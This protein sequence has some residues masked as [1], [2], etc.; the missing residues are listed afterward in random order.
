MKLNIYLYF[1]KTQNCIVNTSFTNNPWA[2][3]NVFM[4]PDVNLEYRDLENRIIG[5]PIIMHPTPHIPQDIPHPQSLSP[6]PQPQRD[7]RSFEIKPRFPCSRFEKAVIEINDL[8]RFHTALVRSWGS[9]INDVTQIF[10]TSRN[11]MLFSTNALTLLSQNS[12]F[13]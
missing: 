11:V 8:Y 7:S 10:L 4:G 9:F 13:P 3:I 6:T 2:G 12:W 5:S 1:Q